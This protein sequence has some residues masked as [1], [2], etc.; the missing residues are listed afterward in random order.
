MAGGTPANHASLALN[1]YAGGQAQQDFRHRG[2]R[3][4]AVPV[5]AVENRERGED[6]NHVLGLLERAART[7]LTRGGKALRQRAVFAWN[8]EMGCRLRRQAPGQ[9]GVDGPGS[10]RRLDP[11][12]LSWGK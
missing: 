4:P 5:K 1:Q 7:E 3:A 9:G 6:P 10:A 8:L 11:L 12:V 2:R